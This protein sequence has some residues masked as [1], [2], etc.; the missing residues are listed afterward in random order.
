VRR[1]AIIGT[2]VVV[3]GLA[4]ALI[5]DLTSSKA[6]TPRR[7]S[8]PLPPID[9]KRFDDNGTTVRIADL[10]GG[11]PMVI[12]VWSS[13]CVPC[14]QETPAIERVYRKAKGKVVIVGVNVSDTADTGATFI[15]KYGATYTQVRDP[16]SQLVTALGSAVLPST[17]IVDRDG[18]IVDTELGAVTTASLEKLLRDDLGIDVR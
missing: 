10:G 6:T 14:Q 4:V 1:L 12:N 7:G 17:F 18:R 15:R 5:V 9:M 11:K 8:I 2:A 13:T 3:L 16:R